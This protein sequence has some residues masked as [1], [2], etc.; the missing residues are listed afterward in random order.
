[1]AIF[2]LGLE[3]QVLGLGFKAGS[4]GLATQGL[5][6]AMLG[7]A[8]CDLVNIT[9]AYGLIPSKF[10]VSAAAGVNIGKTRELN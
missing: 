1:L 3:A 6:L 10:W 2:G 8:A 4:L 5:G 7:L 9:G